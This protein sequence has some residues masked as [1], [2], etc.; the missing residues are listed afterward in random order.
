MFR[1]TTELKGL[2][3]DAD[4]FEEKIDWHIFD[5]HYKCFFITSDEQIAGRLSNQYGADTVWCVKK[6]LKLFAPNHVMHGEVLKKMQLKA[7]EIAYLSKNI[8]FLQN[9]MEFLGGTIWITD[10]TIN[11]EEAS[12]A[13]DVIVKSID[14]LS[15]FFRM[16]EKVFME[17]CLC[18]QKRI[19][20]G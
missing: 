15:D 4:S 1:C 3:I 5:V 17:R 18:F 20:E 9:A 13:P 12:N 7:T 2:I 11:Y 14:V 19:K 10:R 6:Y 16:E 8:Q